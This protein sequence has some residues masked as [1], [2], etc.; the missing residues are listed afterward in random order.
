MFTSK[1]DITENQPVI[2][3]TGSGLLFVTKR[4]F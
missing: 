2:I 1:K 4:N 3:S